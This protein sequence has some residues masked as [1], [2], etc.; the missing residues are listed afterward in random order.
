MNSIL[1]SWPSP[2]N[3]GYSL[4][5]L[6]CFNSIGMGPNPSQWDLVGGWGHLLGGL[7]GGIFLPLHPLLLGWMLSTLPRMAGT[8]AA[9]LGR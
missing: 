4:S 1:P 9:V 6:S 2:E 7:R 8:V 5:T 3:A